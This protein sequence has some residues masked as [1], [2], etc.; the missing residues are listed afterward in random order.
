MLRPALSTPMQRGS[1]SIGL[2]QRNIGLST[3]L[4][5]TSSFEHEVTLKSLKM[6]VYMNL[7]PQMK[8][9]YPTL[10]KRNANNSFWGD[11]VLSLGG[12]F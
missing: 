4:N 1:Q 7:G 6:F 5:F 2:W 8:L 9:A 10:G 3:V 11:S 12:Q